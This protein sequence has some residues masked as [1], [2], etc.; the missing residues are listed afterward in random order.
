MSAA[1]IIN[2]LPKLSES[3]RREVRQK[4]LELAAENEDIALCNQAALEGAMMLDP[5]EE[6]DAR[7][8]Q[9]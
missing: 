6:E 8:Q 1:E 2:K 5:M 9:R 3:E 7:R 4:L